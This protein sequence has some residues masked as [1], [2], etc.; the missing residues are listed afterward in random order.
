MRLYT[1]K[2]SVLAF[3]K[4]SIEQADCFAYSKA[5]KLV[6]KYLGTGKIAKIK[7]SGF[8]NMR[9]TYYVEHN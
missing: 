8:E 2:I 6:E 7:S 1:K 5:I 9:A 3:A 4:Y